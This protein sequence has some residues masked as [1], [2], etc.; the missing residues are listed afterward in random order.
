MERVIG[1]GAESNWRKGGRRKGG[2]KTELIQKSTTKTG[3]GKI[4][5]Q[6]YPNERK[7]RRPN[8]QEVC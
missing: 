5:W 3:L 6:D 1:D 8:S 7:C 2:K 4:I